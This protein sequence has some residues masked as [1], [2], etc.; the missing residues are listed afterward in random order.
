MW[1]SQRKIC[2]N[3]L[4][5]QVSEIHV[6]GGPT[7]PA[8]RPAPEGGPEAGPH[9]EDAEAVGI[10]VTCMPMI[11]PELNEDQV[12]RPQLHDAVERSDKRTGVHQEQPPVQRHDGR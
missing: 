11:R 10:H 9:Q 6:S 2:L 8:A 5:M 7:A 3:C 12:F 4:L 1:K